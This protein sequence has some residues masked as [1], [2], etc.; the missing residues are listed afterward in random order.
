MIMKQFLAVELIFNSFFKAQHIELSLWKADLT[1]LWHM[2]TL[3]KG[4][5]L[6]ALARKNIYIHFLSARF[7]NFNL[8]LSVCC[9]VQGM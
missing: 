6:D 8:L 7:F 4:I 2:N 5:L 9:K 3:W 1:Q